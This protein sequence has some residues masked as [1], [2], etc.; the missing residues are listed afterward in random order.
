VTEPPLLH[1]PPPKEPPNALARLA[2]IA[3]IVVLLL[4]M[5]WDVGAFIA[6]LNQPCTDP[7]VVST[8]T[9]PTPFVL[10]FLGIGWA[11]RYCWK[12]L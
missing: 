1:A 4:V 12:R 2:L 8:C 6:Y 9:N 3:V 7:L 5:L 11:I 10:I